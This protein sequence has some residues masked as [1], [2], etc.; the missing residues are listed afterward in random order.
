MNDSITGDCCD[1]GLVEDDA[2]WLPENVND[3]AISRMQLHQN[4]CNNDQ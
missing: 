4:T 3:S 2:E 1:V